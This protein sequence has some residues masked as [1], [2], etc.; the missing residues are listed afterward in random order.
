MMRKTFPFLGECM[1]EMAALGGADFRLGF[2]GD[3]MNTAWYARACLPRESW[4]VSYFT[5]LGEDVYSKKMLAFF[6]DNDID[7]S[8]IRLHPSRR[9]GLYMIEITNGERSFTTGAI[10]PRPRPWQMTGCA[11]RCISTG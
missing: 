5:R 8:L 1:I 9:P 7:S 11:G 3:T 6:Q 4:D 10:S 2:A